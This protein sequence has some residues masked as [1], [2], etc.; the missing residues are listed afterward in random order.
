M[1]FIDGVTK[2][3][4]SLCFG[5]ES[6][7]NPSAVVMSQLTKSGEIIMQKEFSGLGGSYQDCFSCEYSRDVAEFMKRYAPIDS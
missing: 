7:N 2:E 1:S 5:N 4:E 6:G 3:F